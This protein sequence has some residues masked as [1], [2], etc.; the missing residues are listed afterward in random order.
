MPKLEISLERGSF[1]R[2]ILA[3]VITVLFL[4]SVLT[5]DGD[6]TQGTF[7]VLIGLV[8]TWQQ[9]SLYLI[10]QREDRQQD[11]PADD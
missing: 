8:L 4:I 9:Y 1:F 6:R 3:L 5:S 7:L 2:V 11:P 10:K